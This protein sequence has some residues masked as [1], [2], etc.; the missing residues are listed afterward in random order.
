MS[1]EHEKGEAMRLLRA[2]ED[3]STP[4]DDIAERVEHTDPALVYLILGWLRAHY[5]P[6]HSASDGVLGRIV[7]TLGERR[8]IAAHVKRG[9]SDPVV[10]WFEDAYDYGELDRDDFVSLVVDKLEG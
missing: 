6:G 7:A 2:I 8:G 3:G 4:T 1:F 10:A 5:R 9:E